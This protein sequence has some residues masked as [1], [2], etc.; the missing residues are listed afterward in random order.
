MK[1]RDFVPLLIAPVLAGRVRAASNDPGDWPQW[2]G[3]DR[4]GISQETGLAKSWPSAGPPS[5]WSIS[6]LGQGYGA[7]A[8]KGDRIYVQ[9]VEGRNSVVFCL[10]R[11]D[12]KIVWTAALAEKM[13]QDRGS[14]PR[15]TPT[16]DG[17]RGYALSENGELACLRLQD[18]TKIWR[19]NI[20]QDF[21]GRNPHWLLSESPLIDGNR[22]IVTPGGPNACIVALDKSSGKQIWASQDLS[23]GAGYSSCIIGEVQGV[24]AIMTLTDRAGVG[25]RASDGK[26][27]WRYDKVAN[28]TANV[29]TPIFHDNAVF[30]T[31]DYGTGCALLGLA[32]QD[33]DVK[34][35]EIYFSRDMQNH[36]G[37]VILH[38]GYLYGFS[39]AILT[40]MEFK[41]GR[42]AWKDRS[43][44]KGS[45][46]YADGNLYLL[47]E[48][49]VA[50]LAEATPDAYRERGRFPIP[51]Q[52]LPSWAHPVVCGRR[53]YLRNQSMLTCYDV[54]A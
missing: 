42:V 36:H 21:G 24:R 27:M 52:G 9:G 20:L 6:N 37:G 49:N 26:L 41:T 3:P 35:E 47:S 53:L 33:G 17:D 15:G 46:T 22:V 32:A 48:S 29:T 34:A 7:V 38:N 1:R 40:C 51:D 16:L 44:G 14:G 18:G 2:R 45:L 25:V 5:I 19:R 12:G 50:G 8:I 43:V 23:D 4:N 11:R 39:S 28:R 13:E 54:K 30:Y 31:S 10:N